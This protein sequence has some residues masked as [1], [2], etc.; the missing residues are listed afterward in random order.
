MRFSLAAL[1]LPIAVQAAHY[2]KAEYASG[3]IHQKLMKLK[4][5]R[6]AYPSPQLLLSL[7]L[8]PKKGSMG[9]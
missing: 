1:A 8:T 4:T 3:E 5:V 7:L 9:A 6:L 2:S